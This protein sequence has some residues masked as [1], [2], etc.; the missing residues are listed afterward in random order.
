[1][2]TISKNAGL[3]GL[4]VAVD[5][6][7]VLPDLCESSVFGDFHFDGDLHIDLGVD[8]HLDA[9]LYFQ[10]SSRR[11]HHFPPHFPSHLLPAQIAH[12]HAPVLVVL[13]EGVLHVL[14]IPG[15]HHQH[16]FVGEVDE[17]GLSAHHLV[18]LLEL[19]DV[20]V[21]LLLEV[22]VVGDLLVA[23]EVGRKGEK[24]NEGVV[25]ALQ[26]AVQLERKGGVGLG[27]GRTGRYLE[28]AV[29]LC[30]L[31]LKK[32]VV[33]MVLSHHIAVVLGCLY[34]SQQ[35][36]LLMWSPIHS[37]PI[38]IHPTP[39]SCLVFRPVLS[40]PDGVVVD[41]VVRYFLLKGVR[42]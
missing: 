4:E 19:L 7:Q 33:R 27:L 35:T 37:V 29:Q 18:L 15:G 11:Q 28:Y 30:S 3:A 8:A 10:N 16:L 34:N 1:M 39:V 40:D 26:V 21:E 32:M 31:V 2:D 42:F 41:E 14:E 5:L 12:A 24:V 9:P 23:V 36:V 6:V 20:A 25:L 17:L 13:L 22:E 38:S